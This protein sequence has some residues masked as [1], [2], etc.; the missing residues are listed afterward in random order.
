MPE[1]AAYE[2]GGP[3]DPKV[4]FRR[5]REKLTVVKEEL[6]PYGWR[7]YDQDFRERQKQEK[8]LQ[9]LNR[10]PG[11]GAEPKDGIVPGTPL[12]QERLDKMLLVEHLKKKIMSAHGYFV[13]ASELFV[14]SHG[15]LVKDPLLADKF[16]ECITHVPPSQ[17]DRVDLLQ[18]ALV[19]SRKETQAVRA[20]FEDY[21]VQ[22]KIKRE[23]YVQ[24]TFE[25]QKIA[26]ARARKDQTVILWS[27]QTQRGTAL[28][29]EETCRT[30]TARVVSL[31]S[32]Y[33]MRSEELDE[34]RR[35]FEEAK[36]ELMQER[37]KFKKL[38]NKMV[39]AHEKALEDLKSCEGSAEDMSKMILVLSTEKNR[40]AQEVEELEAEKT[41]LLKQ[42]ADA[43]DEI[44][45]IRADV[46]LLREAARTTEA[47]LWE[48]QQEVNQLEKHVTVLESKL[49][50]AGKLVAVLRDELKVS[51]ADTEAARRR[52][53][54]L[55]EDVEAERHV[56]TLAGAERDFVLEQM[57]NAE[58]QIL[59]IVPA[60]RREVS[61]VKAQAKKEF[62]DF[63]N[64][65]LKKM[66]EDFR[67]KT[68]QI[69]RRNAILEREVAIG[70][71]CGPHLATLNPVTV[72]SGVYCSSCKKLFVYEGNMKG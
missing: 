4:T 65:E 67:R 15:W 53:E 42:L 49:D 46:R 23:K 61:D 7:A 55:E 40:L 47:A 28:R 31:E 50:E 44:A 26:L 56:A 54:P 19:A 41:K 69:L 60:W 64:G 16:A 34:S 45:K 20:E 39:K 22:L 70:D 24:R 3:N 66:K 51:R 72:D 11:S 6:S 62:D 48:E 52:L 35:Q 21:I 18:I 43:K 36:Q 57:R 59:R 9:G 12:W 27:Y 58:A 33:A 25:N 1:L 2:E 17:H 10:L 37:D 32:Q 14:Q 5:L 71:Q 38:Y 30:L 13:E 8:K 63:K 68:D 29:L